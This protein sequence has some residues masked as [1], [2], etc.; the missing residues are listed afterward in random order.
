MK[1]FIVLFAFFISFQTIA[2]PPVLKCEKD[3]GTLDINDDFTF[4]A[5]MAQG[6]DMWG[7]NVTFIEDDYSYKLYLN[8]QNP[9]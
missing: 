7:A 8:A 5:R 1:I 6:E 9:Y 4:Q 2:Q 3:C